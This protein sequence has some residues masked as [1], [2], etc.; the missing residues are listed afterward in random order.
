MKRE[1]GSRLR[2]SLRGLRAACCRRPPCSLLRAGQPKVS[3]GV[4]Q[5]K[6]A[7]LAAGLHG[8]RL[9]RAVA[10]HGAPYAHPEPQTP[11]A[12]LIESRNACVSPRVLILTPSSPRTSFTASK[13]S[14]SSSAEKSDSSSSANGMDYVATTLRR[15]TRIAVAESR[16]R[17]WKTSSAS[18]FKSS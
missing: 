2:R 18:R 15:N 9:Q 6:A 1:F 13:I 11:D 5:A 10:V 8:P 16:P 12:Y 14:S 7:G 4:F 3:S 17:L